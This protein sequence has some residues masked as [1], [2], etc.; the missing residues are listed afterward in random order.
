MKNLKSLNLIGSL[1][2]SNHVNLLELEGGFAKYLG[3]NYHW[4]IAYN[5]DASYKD[6]FIKEKINMIY[7]SKSLV[8]DTRFINDVGWKDF[9]NHYRDHGFERINVPETDNF[10]LV[11][12]NI[13]P[14][15]K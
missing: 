12:S 4:V 10:I 8:N 15:V 2:I 9:L 11:A 14:H 7:V 3:D 13:L 5:K 1:G 6:F